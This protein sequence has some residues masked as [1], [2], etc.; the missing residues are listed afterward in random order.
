MSTP[1]WARWALAVVLV[2]GV[3]AAGVAANLAILETG[4]DGTRLGTLSARSISS[5]ATP[6]PDS[7]GAGE[8]TTPAADSPDAQGNRDDRDDHTDRDDDEGEDDDD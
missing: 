3:A 7:S 5:G 1:P 2:L 4:N 8:A 6:R